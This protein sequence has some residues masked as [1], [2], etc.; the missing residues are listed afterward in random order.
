MCG[1]YNIIED[2]QAWMDALE[3]VYSIIDEDRFEPRYNISPSEPPL[4]AGSQR[5]SPRRIT[6]VPIVLQRGDELVGEDAIWPLIPVWARGEVPKYSTANARSEEIADKNAYRNAWKR[7]QRC[8]IYATGFYEWQARPGH[9]IKQPW[10]IRLKGQEGFALG[11][12]WESSRVSDGT[13]V[14]SCT[15]VT[16]PANELMR[17]IHNAGRNRH[18]MPLILTPDMQKDWLEAPVDSAMSIVAAVPSDILEAWPVSTAV[19]NPNHNN[20]RVLEPIDSTN[21]DAGLRGSE[22]SL[23]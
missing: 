5:A 8:L 12:L 15:I 16:L 21:L 19:N 14:L 22:S 4:P 13:E 23:L 7:E 1:R 18:R 6:R 2:P 9:R 11:G 3:V 10:H 17:D 20:A